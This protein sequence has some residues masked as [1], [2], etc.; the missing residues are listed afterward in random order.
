METLNSKCI[1]RKLLNGDKSLLDHSFHRIKSSEND[2]LNGT[3]ENNQLP[4]IK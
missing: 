4:A 3:F 1:A 2:Q